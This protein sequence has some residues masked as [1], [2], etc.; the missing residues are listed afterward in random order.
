MSFDP[1]SPNQK[2]VTKRYRS[3]IQTYQLMRL[4]MDSFDSPEIKKH[5]EKI[6][7]NFPKINETKQ[8]NPEEIWELKEIEKEILETKRFYR[9]GMEE[10]TAKVFATKFLLLTNWIVFFCSIIFIIILVPLGAD[11]K[12]TIAFTTYNFLPLVS[13]FAWLITWAKWFEYIPL[14]DDEARMKLRK[15]YEKL[16]SELK[17]SYTREELIQER[18]NVIDLFLNDFFAMKKKY[19]D[20][21]DRRLMLKYKTAIPIFIYMLCVFIYNLVM[22]NIVE[23]RTEKGEYFM[24]VFMSVVLSLLFLLFTLCTTF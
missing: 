2:P 4:V 5:A 16:K 1:S 15:E 10:S 7:E 24:G 13:I 3:S 12:L 21:K 19:H 18:K 14:D 20:L 23:D 22:V 17:P 11:I 8:V 6:L 9:Q